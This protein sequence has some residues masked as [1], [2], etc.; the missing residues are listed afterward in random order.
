MPYDVVRPK[1]M[2]ADWTPDSV[3]DQ[4]T[5]PTVA[6]F[7]LSDEDWVNVQDCEPPP[8]PPVVGSPPPVLLP[9]VLLPPVPPVP[10]VFEPPAPVVPPVAGAPP[11][12]LPPM[13]PPVPELPPELPLHPDVTG[14]RARRTAHANGE[15]RPRMKDSFVGWGE[16][17]VRARAPPDYIEQGFKIVMYQGAGLRQLPQMRPTSQVPCPSMPGK[18]APLASFSVVKS[19]TEPDMMSAR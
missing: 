10:P 7:W 16:S 8:V 15:K 4:V 2:C 13:P 12:L 11:L 18:L 14:A 6:I 19:R 3:V 5:M 17:V 9:P 1:S